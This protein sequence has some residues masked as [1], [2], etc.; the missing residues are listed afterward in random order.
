MNTKELTEYIKNYLEND[1]TRSA[2]MLTGEWGCGKSYYIQNTLIPEIANGGENRC[3]I[4]SLYGI[5]TLEALS[6]S[7]YLDMWEEENLQN[8][9]IL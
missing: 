3:I 6:K 2:I 5:K 7:I 4:V 1:R 8:S 9:W